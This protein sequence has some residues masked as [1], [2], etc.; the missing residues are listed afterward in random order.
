MKFKQLRDKI[1]NELRYKIPKEKVV[2]EED[3]N[4]QVTFKN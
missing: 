3:Y 1:F 2:P 4:A